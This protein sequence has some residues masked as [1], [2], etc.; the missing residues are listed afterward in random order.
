VQEARQIGAAFI[1]REGELVQR[2]LGV[3]SE[4]PISPAPP[5]PPACRSAAALKRARSQAAV[6][7]ASAQLSLAE[8]RRLRGRHLWS[9]E[10]RPFFADPTAAAHFFTE[11]YEPE[12]LPEAPG[13]RERL[14]LL[15]R[16]REGVAAPLSKAPAPR[17][18]AGVPQR[19]KRTGF[20]DAIFTHEGLDCFLR[21]TERGRAILA[22][23]QAE[24]AAEAAQREQRSSQIND[25]LFSSFARDLVFREPIYGRKGDFLPLAPSASSPSLPSRRAAVATRQRAGAR[26]LLPQPH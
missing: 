9:R 15:K 17:L 20:T 21:K 14:A 3:P 10:A 1:E 12:R 11:L 7:E 24:A 13:V 22:R 8:L 5:S 23:K 6:Q 18:D 16:Q 4:S 25:P 19:P 26:R 2:R